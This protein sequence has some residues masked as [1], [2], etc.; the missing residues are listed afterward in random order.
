MKYLWAF[1]IFLYLFSCEPGVVF[2]KAMPPDVPPLQNIPTQFMGAYLCESDSSRIY[3]FDHLAFKESH[4]EFITTIDKIM[5]TE[6]CAILDG[7]LYLPGR[8]ECVPFNYLS[9]DSINATV[10]DIDTLFNFR[11]FEVA[12][13]HKGNLFLNQLDNQ[14]NWITWILSPEPKGELLLKFIDIPDKILSVESITD[15]YTTRITSNDQVQYIINPT[16]AQF[17]R[18][19]DKDL[20]IACERL[21]PIGLEDNLVRF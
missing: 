21:T 6:D 3:I 20:T 5:G 13:M 11:D 12:K 15:D 19:L 2:E 16:L 10:Y 14:N 17:E 4:F 9:A 7:G 18:I 8:D 1:S